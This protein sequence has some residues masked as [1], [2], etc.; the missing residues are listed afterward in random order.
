MSHHSSDWNDDAKRAM[1]AAMASL[2]G[3]F[4]NGKLNTNDDGALALRWAVRN[5]LFN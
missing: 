5:G 2:L 1:S 3:E 4:P